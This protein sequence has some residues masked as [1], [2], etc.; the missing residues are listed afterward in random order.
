MVSEALK[1]LRERA[2]ERQGG[3]DNSVYPFWNINFG[4][5][6]TL[7]LIPFEYDLTKD[8]W[9][10]KKIIR[11]QFV[12]PNDDAKLIRFEAPCYE[13]YSKDKKCPVLQPVRDLYSEAKG[14]KNA[15]DTTEAERLEKVA[16]IHWIKPVFYYQGFVIKSGIQESELP[17]NP[18]RVFPMLKQIHQVIFSKLMSEEEDAFDRLPT[19]E[20]TP[21]DVELLLNGEPSDE[22][23]ERLL[24]RF[25]GI[26]FIL[27]KTKQGEYANYQTSS[28]SS[29]PSM[30]DE[31]QIQAVQKYGLHDL[32]KRLPDQPSEEQYEIMTEMVNVS[33]NRLLGNDD[34]YWNPEWEE[35]GLKPKEARD[36]KSG[37]DSDGKPASKR[38]S[39]GVSSKLKSQLNKA[40]GGNGEAKDEPEEKAESSKVSESVMDKVRKARGAKASTPDEETPKADAD[41]EPVVKGTKS[42]LAA[43]IRG[44]LQKGAE[45]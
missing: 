35:A 6:A 14:L 8:F 33:I 11:M 42:D 44:K 21:D 23:V 34:G 38:S 45:A 37:G 40:R 5:S 28:W 39:G 32:R 36:Q 18:I 12:D 30:L 15:G 41:S 26:N 9:T 17:E 25:E 20:F 4:D 22:E 2:K 43:R 1:R 13:M 31:E 19:G 16:G 24:A 7:R 27:R 29:S 10:E 3:S